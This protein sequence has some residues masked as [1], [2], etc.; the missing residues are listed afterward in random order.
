MVMEDHMLEH[1]TKDSL[2]RV[3]YRY[4]PSEQAA[5][6]GH[7]MTFIVDART[8]RYAGYLP[9]SGPDHG[10]ALISAQGFKKHEPGWIA[11]IVKKPQIILGAYREGLRII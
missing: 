1:I 7:I 11:V 3:E 4:P 8:M 6:D 5:A 2:G 10:T 9:G